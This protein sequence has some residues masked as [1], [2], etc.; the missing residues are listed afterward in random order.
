MTAEELLQRYAA[1]ERDF[2][3]VSL[4]ECV[5]VNTDLRGVN[6]SGADL[7]FAELIGVKLTEANLTKANFTGAN[8]TGARLDSSIL[9]NA[10]LECDAIGTVFNNADLR[11]VQMYRCR[12]RGARFENARLKDSILGCTDLLGTSFRGA[13]LKNSDLEE[14]V[15]IADFTDANLLGATTYDFDFRLGRSI[16]CRTI[17]QD[18]SIRNDG[19]LGVSDNK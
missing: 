14:A 4:R 10:S 9:Q 7:R 19:C 15:G 1:G 16:F 3:G 18:G 5:L 17:M 2:A 11:G 8:L 6:L 13:D 12:L